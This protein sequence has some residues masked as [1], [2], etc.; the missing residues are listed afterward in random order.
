MN[1]TGPKLKTPRSNQ[2]NILK[3]PLV[4]DDELRIPGLFEEVIN[5]SQS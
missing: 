5:P 1:P 4:R 2:K 3:A